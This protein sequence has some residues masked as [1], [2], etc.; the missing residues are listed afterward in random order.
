MGIVPR[1]LPAKMEKKKKLDVYIVRLGL[2]FFEVSGIEEL[3][4]RVF[5]GLHAIWPTDFVILFDSILGIRKWKLRLLLG[6]WV[7]WL[8]TISIPFQ[9]GSKTP[10]SDTKEKQ[11]VKL[12]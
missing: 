6:D 5:R 9:S 7:E 10:L 4:E 3:L 2:V 11:L 12:C 8:A 1:K